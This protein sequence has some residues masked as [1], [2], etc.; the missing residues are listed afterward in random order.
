MPTGYTSDVQE[1]K[2]T[3][4]E[5][6]VTNCA[7]AFLWQARDSSEPDLRKLVSSEGS[8]SYY[9]KSLE[10]SKAAL[11][12][13]ESLDEAGW[14]KI[15]DDEGAEAIRFAYDY[16]KRK[17]EERERYTAMINKV[18]AWTPPTPEHVKL[19]EFMIEQLE[20]SRKFDCD[21]ADWE[22]KQESFD[23]WKKHKYESA[24]VRVKRDEADVEKQSSRKNDFLGWVNDLLESVK[25][26]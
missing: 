24:L 22:V 9:V 21:G 19:K 26:L 1:G 20:S 12:K 7:R 17:A 10:E 25:G 13:L 2:V 23:S 14:R 18:N 16:N 6:F 8:L 11:A 15:Y 5:A 3:T 4:L